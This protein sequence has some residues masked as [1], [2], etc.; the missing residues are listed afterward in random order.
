MYVFG[1][2]MVIGGDI[3]AV[4]AVWTDM[5][6]FPEWDPREE[7]TRLDGAFGPG[8]TGYSR[9][10][11]NPGGPFTVTIVEPERRWTAESPLPGG[12]LV[13]HH[14]LEPAG[15]NRVRVAKRYEVHGPLIPLFRCYYGPRVRRA[16]GGTFAALET[17]AA[18]RGAGQRP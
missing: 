7:E 15:G 14:L 16:L 5:E 13:I 6:R 12:R 1:G 10:R 8:A 4:W 2:E 17:E 11:G 18:R 9:Q 3:G